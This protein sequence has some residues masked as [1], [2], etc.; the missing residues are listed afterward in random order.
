MNRIQVRILKTVVFEELQPYCGSTIGPC[1]C[2]RE[3]Q[4]F[5]TTYQKPD[6]FCD[7]AW[8]DIHPHVT[9]FMTGGDFSDGIFKGWMKDR[10]VMIA[11]CTDGARPV[12]FEIR[13]LE[14]E[15]G[16]ESADGRDA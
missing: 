10:N 13:K 6:G 11:C 4:V 2:F 16:D 3:G 1:P 5:E 7:W 8:H 14:G 12:V 15:E 9:A